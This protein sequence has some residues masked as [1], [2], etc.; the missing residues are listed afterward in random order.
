MGSGKILDIGCA[1]ASRRVV[2]TNGAFEAKLRGPFCETGG[3]DMIAEDILRPGKLARLGRDFE[4]GFEHLLVVVVAR[5]Q[6]HPV[7]AE[8]DRLLIVIRRD[9]PD[10]EN[11]HCSPTM[12]QVPMTCIFRA[13]KPP[14][15]STIAV[16][17]STRVSADQQDAGS[18]V[19]GRRV[20]V[21]ARVLSRGRLAHIDGA[22]GEPA[23][24]RHLSYLR[25]AAD[26]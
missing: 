10:G 3:R 9:V 17:D 15:V 20:G 24:R 25:L 22:D 18:P 14:R 6:H 19:G 12:M 4:L 5:T 21:G 13:K 7:L 8:R 23:G 16:A 11:R 1:E 26:D 2:D